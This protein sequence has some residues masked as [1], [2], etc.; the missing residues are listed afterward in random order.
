MKFER[1]TRNPAT[2]DSTMMRPWPCRRSCPAM[3]VMAAAGQV[4]IDR[5]HVDDP[6]SS[7][8]VGCLRPEFPHGDDDEI[9][10]F[11]RH[12]EAL[13]DA[14][15]DVVEGSGVEGHGLN[16]L[17][18]DEVLCCSLERHSVASGE[19]D[20]SPAVGNEQS[21]KLTGDVR[22]PA[23][24]EDGLRVTERVIHRGI[25]RRRER[26]EAKTPLGSTLRRTLA[27]SPSLGYMTGRSSGRSRESLAR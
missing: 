21:N 13:L 18:V 16:T 6:I 26:S 7:E 2:D 3:A 8:L 10:R 24:H 25:R 17:H 14:L 20:G 4:E 1:R 23:E 5:H 12:L 27:M 9:N 19:N 15:V 11:V 22:S